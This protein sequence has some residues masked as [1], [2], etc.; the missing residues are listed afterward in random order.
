MDLWYEDLAVGDEVRLGSY[1]MDKAEM[2]AF[3]RRWDPRPFHVDEDF[4]A[5]TLYGGVTASSVLTFGVYTKLLNEKTGNWVAR[6]A[7]GYET[8]RFPAAVLAG[9]VLTGAS[10][11]I[12][13]RLS[14]SRPGYGIIKTRDWLAK[15]DGKVVLEV[16][17]AVLLVR[18]P[19]WEE[20]D[21]AAG[22]GA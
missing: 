18:K 4:A 19:G 22:N 10:E 1:T 3:A 12:E 6:G 8:T 7:L 15:Q 16:V 2:L 17:P 5:T 20:R 13:K 9:D 11:V 21:T 14:Q